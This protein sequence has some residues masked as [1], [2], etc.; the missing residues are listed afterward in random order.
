MFCHQCGAS[1]PAEASFC[2]GCGTR[3]VRSVAQASA[4]TATVEGASAVPHVELSR[5]PTLGASASQTGGSVPRASRPRGVAILAA[6]AFVVMVATFCIGIAVSGI[7]ASASAQSAVPLMQALMRLFPVLAQGE[8]ELV[9]QASFVSTA[10]FL[11]AAICA[12]LG[13]GLWTLR[14]W[15]HIFANVISVLFSFRAVAMIL[16]LPGTFVWNLFVLAINIWII[17]YLMK[18]RVKQSF[19]R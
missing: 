11:I 14:K 9:S 7:A 12:V 18:P 6:L 1:L 4:V 17:T 8:Q 16:L 19:P 3:S 2:S 5:T 13:Y 15:A 10:M